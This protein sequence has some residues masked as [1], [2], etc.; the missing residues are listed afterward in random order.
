MGLI[1]IENHQLTFEQI[2]EGHWP[3]FPPYF[4]DSLS[5]CKD[6][7][8]DRQNFQLQTSGSTG[9]PKTISVTRNQMLL[10]AGATGKFF[11]IP[12]NASLFCCLNTAMIAGKMMLVRAMVWDSCLYLKE[13]TGNPLSDL[14]VDQHFDFVAMV[15]AQVEN[16]LQDSRTIENLNKIAHLIIG[17]A[18]ISP[19]LQISI[20]HLSCNAYQTYGMTET[21]S[22]IALAKITGA[23]PLIYQSLPGVKIGTTAEKKLTIEAPMALAPLITNDI[24][25]LLSENQFIWKGRADFTINS[26]GLKIQPEILETKIS[27]VMEKQWGGVRYFISS[28]PSKKWGEEVVLIIEAVGSPQQEQ[29]LQEEMAE[30]LGK[31]ERPKKVYFLENFIETPSGK[32]KRRDNTTIALEKS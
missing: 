23:P 5:F 17:G 26:G 25:E 6:W 16:S 29:L 27:P 13:P 32:I 14:V 1:I 21:V 19:Q 28:R 22:H 30:I 7:L 4:E 24:V 11:G 2:K 15:P 9:K 31:Y 10:S 18:P 3:A 12:A 8:N 20:S